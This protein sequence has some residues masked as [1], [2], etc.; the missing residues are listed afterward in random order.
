MQMLVDAAGDQ[1]PDHLL[2]FLVML[3]VHRRVRARVCVCERHLAMIA[4]MCVCVR[5]CVCV[6]VCVCVPANSV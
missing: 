6:R 3:I 1:F 5:A 4:H 2:V